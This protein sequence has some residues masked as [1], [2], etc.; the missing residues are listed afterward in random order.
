MCC[1]V[2]VSVVLCVTCLTVFVNC[3]VKQFAV[4]LELVAIL[5]LNAIK[6]FSVLELLCWIGRVWS[7]EYA[8]CACNPS[9]HQSVPSI[10]FVYGLVCRK[11]SAHLGAGSQVFALLLSF[12]CVILLTIWSGKSMH[13]LCILTFGML[14]LCA[15]SMMF[16]G[17]VVCCSERKR[18]LCLP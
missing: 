9:V 17:S 6:M 16:V 3:F 5:L 8:C 11:L 12:L 7:T 10:G 18:T 2:N 1:S 15:I 14:C 13:L 4:C